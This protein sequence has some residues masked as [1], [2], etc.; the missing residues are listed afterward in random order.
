[1]SNYLLLLIAAILWSSAFV[2]IRIGL[3]DYTPGAMALLRFMV[4]SIAMVPLYL[5]YRQPNKGLNFSDKLKILVTGFIGISVYHIALN[6]GEISVPSGTASF[7]ISQSPIL[8]LILAIIFLKERPGLIGWLGFLVSCVGVA[9][10][11]IGEQASVQIDVGL[12]CVGLATLASAY[13]SIS[14]KSLLS[15]VNSVELMTLIIWAG[16][17]GLLMFLPDLAKELPRAAVTST[18]TVI[19]LGIFPG[20]IAYTCWSIVLA[21]MSATRAASFLYLQP[22]LATFMG[23][24]FI[25]EV[26]VLLSVIGGCVAILGAMLV[27]IRRK[28]EC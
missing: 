9:L 8:I 22:L 17:I 12:L 6:Y 5:R 15:K 1:M 16:T 14:Q 13:Y 11:A 10:I 25:N 28:A 24:L 26:P 7:I 19:Y 21:K 2:G 27:Q 4:A 20:V 3:H 18:M 23:W